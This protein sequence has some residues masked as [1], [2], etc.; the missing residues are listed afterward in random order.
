MLD[1]KTETETCGIEDLQEPDSPIEQSSSGGT[2]N[3]NGLVCVVC[4]DQAT[5]RHY[6]SPS[7]NG[8]KGFFR[9]TIRRNY[10]YT[11]RF[12]GNCKID[13]HNRAVCRACRYMRCI[14]FG[15]KVDGKIFKI[16]K[17]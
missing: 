13:R 16:F 2:S 8:C 3:G 11:C 1:I 10:T 4:G 14:N 7:C 15:M 5:G 6:G 17:A 12:N 9:R